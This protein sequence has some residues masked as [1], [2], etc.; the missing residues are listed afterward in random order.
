[1]QICTTS[2]S[3][4]LGHEWLFPV[5]G[6][7]PN[8]K[9]PENQQD[10]RQQGWDKQYVCLRSQAGKT[11]CCPRKK[12]PVATKRPKHMRQRWRTMRLARKTPPRTSMRMSPAAAST[13]TDPMKKC[14]PTGI[15]S[16]DLA[17]TY[18]TCRPEIQRPIPT[19]KGIRS[20]PQSKRLVSPS[21]RLAVSHAVVTR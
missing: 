15:P 5:S 9:Q 7:E 19:S 6:C 10:E 8:A 17:W 12:D 16:V 14:I 13:I 21:P 20:A 18:T 4:R 2:G 1:M 3:F 11:C